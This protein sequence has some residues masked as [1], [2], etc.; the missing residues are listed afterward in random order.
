MKRLILISSFCLGIMCVLVACG[1]F[2]RMHVPQLNP[3]PN[4]DIAPIKQKIYFEIDKDVKDTFWIYQ[5]KLKDSK[6]SNW[7]ASLETGFNNAFN[8]FNIVNEKK[9]AELIFKVLKAKPDLTLVSVKEHPEYD[10]M[11]LVTFSGNI[12]Y[13]VRLIDASSDKILKRL[14]K[15]AESNEKGIKKWETRKVLN[16]AISV[17]Y[18]AVSKNFFQDR[19]L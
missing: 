15:T 1:A 19:S 10:D 12:T 17:M 8:N 7:R 3:D 16:S 13:Q 14:A 5:T 11:Q 18:R 2:T 6:I 4:I 9:K